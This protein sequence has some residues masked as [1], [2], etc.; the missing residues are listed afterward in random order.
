MKQLAPGKSWVGSSRGQAFQYQH[1]V[2][3]EVMKWNIGRQLHAVPYVDGS[4]AAGE[5]DVS[6]V[7]DEDG[8]K[9]KEFTDKN[10]RLILKKSFEYTVT[11]DYSHTGYACTYYIYD[12]QGRLRYVIPPAGVY[13]IPVG[14]DVNGVKEYCYTL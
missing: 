5:L 8:N 7:I 1:N 11:P 13:N 14:W 12:D 3:G 10:G 6:I 2:T 4:Y 9:S